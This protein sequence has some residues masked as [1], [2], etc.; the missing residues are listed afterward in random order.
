MRRRS[1][2]A[3]LFLLVAASAETSH[4]QKGQPLPEVQAV[5][6]VPKGVTPP[7]GYRER[8]HDAAVYAERFFVG[9]MKH[10]KYPPESE[11]FV[12]RDADGKVR[13][14]LVQ[15]DLP[16]TD[17][18][19]R[20]TMLPTIWRTAHEQYGVPRNNPIWW[21]WV[22]EGP[23]PT[24][25]ENW[26]GSGNPSRGGWAKVNYDSS[27]GRLLSNGLMAEGFNEQFKLKGCIHELGH[28]F[29][30]P[31]IGPRGRDDLGN[32]L[33]GPRTAPFHART[34]SK[35]GRAHLSEASAAMLWR[36]WAFS[37]TTWYRNSIADVE[38][39]DLSVKTVDRGARVEV[40]GQLVS[41]GVAHSV[42]LAD[43]AEPNQAAYWRK[44]YVARLDAE[45]RFTVTITEPS[46]TKGTL[47]LV[48]CFRNGA[49]TGNGKAHGLESGVERKYE[50]RRGELVL[51]D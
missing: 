13:V 35:D 15:G 28:G 17:E 4:A 21:V 29:G 38:I 24:R 42:I 6:F 7:E 16:A 26:R 1:R 3:L 30:L 12:A 44:A 14:H 11:Q 10:W 8:V 2:L 5:L 39:R 37:G 20:E 43:D 40:S 47:K 51:V 22:Y 48:F 9:W 25:Y 34:R 45:K 33:M 32:S 36:H 27:P 50:F 49:V 19:Y 18:K 31:H 41:G 23:P 46:G